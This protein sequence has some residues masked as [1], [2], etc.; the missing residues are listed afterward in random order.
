M[1]QKQC[2]ILIDCQNDFF[3]NGSLGI[4]GSK[5]IISNINELIK[6]SRLRDDLI[7]ASKDWHTSNHC[8]FA[9]S[10]P[11]KKEFDEIK[12]NGIVHTLWP[13]HCVANTK[14]AELNSELH[15]NDLEYIVKKG[16][17][18]D[19]E[20]YSVFKD[21]YKNKSTNIEKILSQHSIKKLILVGL[22]LDFCIF[23]SAMDAV[24][25]GYDVEIV[26]NATASISEKRKIQKTKLLKEKGVSFRNV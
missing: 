18:A 17:K 8:S 24:D 3:D 6:Q 13:V 22:A 21:V 4:K 16:T 25:L 23:Y 12:M 5:K 10:H 9:T 14:G 15:L 20:A 1:E 11:G 7:I 19:V 2:L 26:L